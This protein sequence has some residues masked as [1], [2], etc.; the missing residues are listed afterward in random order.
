MK[1]FFQ[2]I[3]R[4]FSD[5]GEP[6]SKRLQSAICMIAGIVFAALKF[7]AEIVWTLFGAAA[8]FQGLTLVR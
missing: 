2:W 6:S 5:N 3:G 1:V 4:V 8:A 7:P